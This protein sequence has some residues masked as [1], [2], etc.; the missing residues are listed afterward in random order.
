MNILGLNSNVDFPI[1]H[2][3]YPSNS[4]STSSSIISSSSQNNSIINNTISNNSSAAN[5]NSTLKPGN[6]FRLFSSGTA[7]ASS[8]QPSSSETSGNASSL[9]SG[10]F[11]IT[12]SNSSGSAKFKA[13]HSRQSSNE[14]LNFVN[15]NYP[16]AAD[17]VNHHHRSAASHSRNQSIELK[18]MK[19]DLG[20][21]LTDCGPGTNGGNY[22]REGAHG[23]NGNMQVNLIVGHHN[24]IA[25]AYTH[26][27]C[28]YKL[29]DGMGWHLVKKIYF[30]KMTDVKRRP[31]CVQSTHFYSDRSG[32]FS[33]TPN[34]F[35]RKFLYLD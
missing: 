8:M 25:V 7:A 15:L 1:H 22:G 4:S 14:L 24:W 9:I 5:P 19:T 2:H 16:S 23:P 20:L 27:V 31:T 33:F 17:F 35:I 28:C 34:Y 13:T 11:Q 32:P 3:H 21:L 12:S 6:V 18:Q 29:K 10:S 30:I 26:Y